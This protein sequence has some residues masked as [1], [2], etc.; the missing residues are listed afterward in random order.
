M[1]LWTLWL[2]AIQSLLT[3]M[4]SEIGLGTGFSIVALTFLL[5]TMILPISWP[6]AYR[7]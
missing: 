7:S 4:S 5:R 2:N 3:F 6:I 1:E